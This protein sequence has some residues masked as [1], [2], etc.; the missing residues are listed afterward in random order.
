MPFYKAGEQSAPIAPTLRNPE[1]LDLPRLSP[2]ELQAWFDNTILALQDDPYVHMDVDHGDYSELFLLLNPEA[3]RADVLIAGNTP[4]REYEAHLQ[5]LLF[6]KSLTGQLYYFDPTLGE[7][8]GLRQIYTKQVTVDGKPDYELSVTSKLDELPKTQPVKPQHPGRWKYLFYPFFAGQFREYKAQMKEYESQT[9]AFEKTKA[10]EGSLVE[11]MYRLADYVEERTNGREGTTFEGVKEMQAERSRAFEEAKRQEQEEIAKQ[12][13]QQEVAN[14]GEQV[15]ENQPQEITR[16]LKLYNKG[17]AEACFKRMTYSKNSVPKNE[18]G[19]DGDKFGTLVAMALGSPD[20]S[21]KVSKTDREQNNPD[22]NYAKVL[23]HYVKLTQISRKTKSGGY[24]SK[25][26]EAV[27]Q[28]MEAAKNGDYSLL[29]KLIAQGLIQNNKVLMGQKQLDH[30]Y[31]IYATLGGNALKL[32]ESNE[33]LKEAV[34]N[35]LGGD[36]KQIDMAKAARNINNL[37]TEI[38]PRYEN[39]LNQFGQTVAYESKDPKSGEKV[40]THRIAVSGNT[41]DVAKVCQ[42]AIIELAMNKGEFDLANNEYIKDGTVEK[43]TDELDRSNVLHDFLRDDKRVERLKDPV[44][45]KDLYNEAVVERQRAHALQS[46]QKEL[47]KSAENQI[48]G[49]IQ[50][51]PVN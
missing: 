42:L 40:V 1:H 44:Q 51:P 48:E 11:E 43:L 2:Q 41:R 37:R 33:Q 29:G 3:D 34:L 22:V 35:H 20:L 8:G 18:L 19:I 45:M 14:H 39:M 46:K 24:L 21:I 9:R 7:V 50:V 6:E 47:A 38:M 15:P 17:D 10:M 27:Q 49:Q 32:M 26:E 16:G 4:I 23:D 5:Q 12:Q 31:T 36:T 28:G 13:E 25:A 30:R